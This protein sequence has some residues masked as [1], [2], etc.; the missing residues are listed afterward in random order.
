MMG[1]RDVMRAWQLMKRAVR[2]GRGEG[3]VANHDA[4]PTCASYMDHCERYHGSLRAVSCVGHCEPPLH[5]C[6]CASIRATSA[7]HM[8]RLGWLD[9]RVSDRAVHGAVTNRCH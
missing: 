8:G 4:R 2:Y 7:S 1:A 6:T 5:R 9:A 3:G